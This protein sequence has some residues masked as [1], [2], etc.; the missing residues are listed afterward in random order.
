MPESFLIKLQAS[1]FL[2]NFVK[3]LRATFFIEKLWWLL[4]S[5]YEKNP[6]I[7]IQK[8]TGNS[9]FSPFPLVFDVYIVLDNN[10]KTVLPVILNGQP[11]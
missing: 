3:F 5:I 8:K 1:S 7:L 9:H 10:K 2:V 11:I 6:E 4:L